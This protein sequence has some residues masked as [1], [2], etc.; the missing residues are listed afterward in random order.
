MH[1]D[2]PNLAARTDSNGRP[3]AGLRLE[4][5]DELLSQF[6]ILSRFGTRLRS[7]HGLGTKRHIK[8]DDMDGSLFM[9]IKLPGNEAWSRVSVDTAM[10]DMDR[11]ARAES[12]DLL[13]RIH[14]KPAPLGPR[15][16]LAAPARQSAIA[17][18]AGPSKPG[19]Q[20]ARSTIPGGPR[21]RQAW[22][23]REGRT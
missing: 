9:N 12:A 22:V 5:P 10:A 15:E 21:P 8:F 4:I 17:P 13:K 3:T 1:V 2:D 6:R 19:S 18:P 16:R 14:S 20:D 23:P 11:V 7:R